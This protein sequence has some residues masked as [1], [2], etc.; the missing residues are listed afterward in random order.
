MPRI[1]LLPWRDQQRRERKLAL[2]VWLLFALIGAALVTGA[3]YLWMGSLIEAQNTR[4]ERLQAEIRILDRQNE[5]INDL[6]SQKQRFISR[7]QVI[8]KLQRSRS[9]IVHVFDELAKIVP[10][11]TY[12]TAVTQTNRKFK[13]EG[14]AQSSTR[15]STFMRSIAA[16]QWLRNP[17]LEVVEARKGNT[18]GNS[19]VLYAEQI[20][21][22]GD[23][24]ETPA[25]GAAKKPKRTASAG[26]A[27]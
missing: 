26:G 17:E 21:L 25:A 15:V 22:P 1:N 24:L 6:E 4:N 13:L 23:D 12:L 11:G 19:F 18:L 14:V 16:S 27:K 7:M 9:E 20:P 5:E 2:Y 8:D 3:G 10:D